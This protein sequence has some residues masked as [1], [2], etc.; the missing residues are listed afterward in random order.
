MK[1][2]ITLKFLSDLWN[3]KCGG[4]IEKYLSARNKTTEYG[5]TY[6]GGESKVYDYRA[7]NLYQLAQKLKIDDTLDKY[8]SKDCI[9]NEY[10]TKHNLH[11]KPVEMTEEEIFDLFGF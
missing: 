6:S 7:E 9:Y 4:T 11:E 10:K 1:K 5:V 3:Q 8:L 2:S